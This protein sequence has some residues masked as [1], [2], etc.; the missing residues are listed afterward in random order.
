MH[1]HI[2]TADSGI[3]WPLAIAVSLGIHLMVISGLPLLK[4]NKVIPEPEVQKHKVRMTIKEKQPVPVS[5]EKKAGPKP[6]AL[7]P[8][9]MK[10]A[11][12]P[13]KTQAKPVQPMVTPP[14]WTASTKAQPVSAK[15]VHQTPVLK[16][17]V[18]PQVLSQPVATQKAML[19]DRTTRQRK[20]GQVIHP[21]HLEASVTDSRPSSQAAVM[22]TPVATHVKQATIQPV[23][24][25]PLFASN[26][27]PAPV[28]GAQPVSHFEKHATASVSP[29]F[30][31]PVQMENWGDGGLS[32]GERRRI[33]GLFVRGIQRRIA[34]H[35]VYPD[36][37][38]QRG[39]GGRTVVAFKLARDGNLVHV[40][41]A[42]SSGF[43]VLDNAAMKAIHDGSPYEAIPARLGDASLSFKLPVSFFIE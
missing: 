10:Q 43:D 33:L 24:P 8:Q 6:K 16:P 11:P 31:Q 19:M 41:V 40:S 18:Q 23:A 12:T 34:S 2:N 1:T 39:M 13:V 3:N 35:Q 14:Q 38:R 7:E 32:E 30:T 37:A 25:P 20:T 5:P 42:Q 36:V 26:E 15:V 27:N 22:Q 9:V 21:V 28:T 29:S 17:Q 4:S